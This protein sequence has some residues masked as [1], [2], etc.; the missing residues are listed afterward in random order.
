MMSRALIQKASSG[1]PTY[2][3]STHTSNGNLIYT[4][5]CYTTSNILI[6]KKIT[7]FLMP[8]KRRERLDRV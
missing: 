3:E 2:R 7:V 6:F 5:M 1:F 4:K 8:G